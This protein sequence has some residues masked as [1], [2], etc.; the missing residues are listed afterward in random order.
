MCINEGY[1]THKRKSYIQY[2]Y[3]YIDLDF[4][5]TLKLYAEN[6]FIKICPLIWNFS[7]SYAYPYPLPTFPL[8]HIFLGTYKNLHTITKSSNRYHFHLNLLFLGRFALS[9]T[10]RPAPNSIAAIRY[11]F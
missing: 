10:C 6:E 8:L 9:D 4:M 1:G 3:T 7:S 11:Q 2:F 5:H